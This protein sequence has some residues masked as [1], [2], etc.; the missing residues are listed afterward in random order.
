MCVGRYYLLKN[1]SS[2]SFPSALVQEKSFQLLYLSVS[3]LADLED[4]TFCLDGRGLDTFLG[5]KIEFFQ[6]FCNQEIW[7]EY[8]VNWQLNVVKPCWRSSDVWTQQGLNGMNVFT[9]HIPLWVSSYKTKIWKAKLIESCWNLEFQFVLTNWRYQTWTLNFLLGELCKLFRVL[10]F[11][12]LEVFWNSVN[13][14][15]V[16]P[17]DSNHI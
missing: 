2:I 12:S 10:C 5:K 8:R 16:S 7:N 1:V 4:N 13:Y 15:S 9:L 6:C 17:I 11:L 14:A 3:K